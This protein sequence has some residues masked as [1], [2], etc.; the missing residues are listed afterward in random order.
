MSRH[1][2]SDTNLSKENQQ[3]RQQLNRL[4]TEIEQLKQSEQGAC[5]REEE[6]RIT[7]ESIGDAV[8]ITDNDAGVKW[9]NSVAKSLTEW[10]CDDAFGQKLEIVF[11]IFNSITGKPA[12]N[13]VKKVSDTGRIVGL[14][15]HTKLISKSGKVY[16]ISDSASPILDS[17]GNISGVVLVFRDVT[18]EY[19]MQEAVAMSEERYRTV[20]ENTGTATVILEKDGAISLA[21]RRF[22]ELSGYANEEIVNKK[23]WM[24]FVVPEDLE[25]MIKQHKLH[26][27]NRE[28]ALRTYEFRFLNKQD[29]IKYIQLHIDVIPRTNQSVASLQD[30]TNL[31]ET[32][33]AL[34]ANSERWDFALQGTGDGVWDW[35]LKNNTVYFS[36]QWKR[37]L[38]YDPNEIE[39]KLSE[40]ETRVH[41]D[42]IELTKAAI[43]ECLQLKNTEYMNEHRLK[44]KQ[45]NY[46]WILD[47]GKVVAYDEQGNPTRFI[48][49]HTDITQR[50]QNEI[51][52]Q[53]TFFGIEN[54]SI[55][56]FEILDDGIIEFANQ[57]ACDSLGYSKDELIGMSLFKVDTSFN[58]ERFKTHRKEINKAFGACFVSRHTRIDGSSFPVEI[59]VNYTEINGKN[60]AFSFV[61]D[62]THRLEVEKTLRE[63]EEKYRLLVENQTDLI[64]KVDVVGKLLFVS[65]S[66]CKMFGKTEKEMLGKTYLP[67]VHEDDRQSTEDAIEQLYEAPYHVKLEHRAFTVN[68]LRW[69]AWSVTAVLDENGKVKEI[70]GIG[71]DITDKKQAELQLSEQERRLSSL[72]GNLPG[73][74]YRCEFDEHWTMRFLSQQCENITSYPPE[75]FLNNQVKAYNDIILPEY[76]QKVADDWEF[77]IEN[78]TMYEGEYQ[79]RTKHNQIKWVWER[80]IGVCDEKGELL[81]LE[82]Y[83]ED[84]TSIKYL[85]NDL[86]VSK[87]K[88][89]ESDRLKTAFLANMSHEIRTPMNGILGFT[90]LLLEPQLT[91]DQVREYVDVIQKS[92]ARMLNTVNDIITISRIETGQVETSNSTFNLSEEIND[93]RKM[94]LPEARAKGVRL[95]VNFDC[96]EDNNNLFTDRSKFDSVMTNLIKNA[97]KFTDKGSIDVSCRE[98]EEMYEFEVKD[99]G[100]GIAPDRILVIFERFIQADI[101]D[102]R[103]LQGSG[104]GLAISKSYVEMM[105]GEIHVYSVVNQGSRFHFTIPKLGKNETIRFE[106]S[107]KLSA[108]MNNLEILIVEDDDTSVKYLNVILKNIAK[109]IQVVNNG[110]EALSLLQKQKDFDVVLM[111]IKL[112]VMNGYEATRKI[113][114]INKDI[115]IIAQTA[116]AISGDREKAIAAGCNDYI[117]KPIVK[118]GLLDILAKY[119]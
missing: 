26:R 107:P 97:I 17:N 61:K 89:E 55:G 60:I 4:Q 39:N 74:V 47:R 90:N 82:G 101:D 99:T 25:R 119:L 117:S 5:L 3:L 37:Q 1:Q 11:P 84:I 73:Y 95:N 28:E 75:T 33:L 66:Y 116:S 32:Q 83:I 112:P 76:R 19:Q 110:N 62:I 91:G 68:S 41:P 109:R 113:R 9:M 93:I 69:L 45:G 59:N 50:K 92:G 63:N 43:H 16:Q 78:K 34:K 42:D 48:G 8:I 118:K 105:G 103:A 108:M 49:T 52:L 27:E 57:A 72:V 18:E 51:Q 23:S 7:M 36:D 14:A 70:L 64:V 71:Q 80:G 94:L 106:T 86:I 96:L 53:T 67:L 100:C 54:A 44:T 13:P 102:K 58:A 20:F 46:K 65:P 40:W 115:V 10:S 31:K 2:K 22:A 29:E 21:N 85:I 114:E 98:T 88:A 24:E 104:L 81:F 35:N 38:G 56:I 77:A 87:N 111:D 30:V 15:N 12:E 79:I 6:L